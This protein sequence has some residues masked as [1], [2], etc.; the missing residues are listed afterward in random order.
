MPDE[1]ESTQ[2]SKRMFYISP[3]IFVALNFLTPTLT[4]MR[5]MPLQPTTWRQGSVFATQW[6][7]NWHHLTSPTGWGVITHHGQGKIISA[8]CVLRRQDELAVVVRIE[9]RPC[10]NLDVGRFADLLNLNSEQARGQQWMYLLPLEIDENTIVGTGASEIEVQLADEIDWTYVGQIEKCPQVPDLHLPQ[11]SSKLLQ[12]CKEDD[13]MVLLAM[14]MDACTPL[15]FSTSLDGMTFLYGR[16][17]T[18]RCSY[19]HFAWPLAAVPKGVDESLATAL[20]CRDVAF[21]EQHNVWAWRVFDTDNKLE[22]QR[23]HLHLANFI[24]DRRGSDNPL[25]RI[26]ATGGTKNE[27]KS[28]TGA[29]EGFDLGRRGEG[30]HR[31]G[32]NARMFNTVCVFAIFVCVL[33]DRMTVYSTCTSKISRNCYTRPNKAEHK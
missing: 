3:F 16:D 21:A 1:S 5:E 18:N 26:E 2:G 4:H 28:F 27:W 11:T 17:L 12:D 8:G 13:P 15:G 22:R 33:H 20:L 10:A 14:N 19:S 7:K 25:G 32:G 9:Q 31:F 6:A 24:S 29:A 23:V 30:N